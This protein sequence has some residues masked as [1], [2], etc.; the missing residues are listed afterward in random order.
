[1][2]RILSQ[3]EAV[4]IGCS[5]WLLEVV[6]DEE[7][8]EAGTVLAAT[9]AAAEALVVPSLKPPA[10]TRSA[11]SPAARAASFL[12]EQVANLENQ[13]RQL[14][15][16]RQRQ[17][18][19]AHDRGRTEAEARSQA[20]L[21][22]EIEPWL[23]RM[24]KSIEDIA[25]VRQRYLRDSEEQLV[26]LSLAIARR[27]LHREIQVDPEALI[28]LVRA[29]IDR[30]ELRELNRILLN[31][32]DREVLQPY[33]DRLHLPPRVEI[34]ADATLERGALLLESGSGLL[35]ASIQSQLDEVERG[36]IDLLG[37]RS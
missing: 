25:T 18:Q 3:P 31:P 5:P 37:R 10:A 30:S 17:V 28:G 35:D 1:M 2:S 15:L 21:K 16:E 26:R 20:R 23:L 24:A 8:L 9:T 34:A 7:G 27:I 33:L 19:E 13:I 36:F 6:A 11:P 22:Q 12:E 29:A 4:T 14:D 32:Q